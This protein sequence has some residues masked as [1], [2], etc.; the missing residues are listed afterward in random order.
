MGFYGVFRDCPQNP[1]GDV[2]GV[3]WGFTGPGK[4]WDDDGLENHKMMCP[5]WEKLAMVK[6]GA[7]HGIVVNPP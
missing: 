1:G 7:F 6:L 2:L 5:T 3:K 4:P